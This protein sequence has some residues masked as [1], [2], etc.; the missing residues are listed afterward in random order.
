[1]DSTILESLKS[2]VMVVFGYQVGN[3]E[4]VTLLA[5]IA[6]IAFSG[7]NDQ[8]AEATTGSS[9]NAKEVRVFRVGEVP[10]LELERI[11]LGK[12]PGQQPLGRISPSHDWE[13]IDTDFYSCVLRNLTDCPITLLD[14]RIRLERGVHKSKGAALGSDYLKERWGETVIQPHQTIERGS[15]WVWGKGEWNNL[16]KNYRAEIQP[17]TSVSLTP[18]LDQ[19]FKENDGDPIPFSF[20]IILPYRR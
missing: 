4:P 8:G 2:G 11:Y 19:F 1:M 15:N 9:R 12:S 17:G 20:Q 5:A 14:V 3:C 18:G 13:S 6:S 10:V 7:C 16:F